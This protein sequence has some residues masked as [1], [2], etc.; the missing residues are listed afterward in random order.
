MRLTEEIAKS[1]DEL[2]S[3]LPTFTDIK[4]L[5]AIEDKMP[6]V[7]RELEVYKRQILKVFVVELIAVAVAFVN[8]FLAVE[9]CIRDR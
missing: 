9:M 7:V 4:E 1:C 3:L 5:R 8:L 2:Q 6:A